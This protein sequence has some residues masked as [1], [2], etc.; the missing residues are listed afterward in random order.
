[1]TYLNKGKNPN[2][3]ISQGS[4]EVLTV[5]TSFS[6]HLTFNTYHHAFNAFVKAL[7]EIAPKFAKVLITLKEILDKLSTMKSEVS[8]LAKGLSSTQLL[9]LGGKITASLGLLG[10]GV[11]VCSKVN[12]SI[13]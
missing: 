5:D 10:A 11:A 1:M 3:K 13:P 9:V 4:D 6:G 7:K 8:N 12:D 2:I